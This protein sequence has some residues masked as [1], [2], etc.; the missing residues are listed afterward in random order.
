M[1]TGTL[2]VLG[3]VYGVGVGY[4]LAFG[5]S[6]LFLGWMFRPDWSPGNERVAKWVMR[7]LVW[8]VRLPFII[9]EIQEVRKTL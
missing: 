5:A 2:T 8:P 3:I 7:C 4:G 1:I 6:I 9:R